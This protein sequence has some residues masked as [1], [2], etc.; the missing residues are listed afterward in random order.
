[1]RPLPAQVLYL[2]RPLMVSFESQAS[3]VLQQYLELPQRLP[4]CSALHNLD[5]GNTE[6]LKLLRRR[7]TPLEQA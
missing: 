1:M 6:K 5:E 3:V 7:W 4:V 2:R